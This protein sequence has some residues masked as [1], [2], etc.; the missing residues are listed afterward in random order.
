[1]PGLSINSAASLAD[2]LTLVKSRTSGSICIDGKRAKFKIRGRFHTLF[3][4]VYD[5]TLK[6]KN[7]KVKAKNF[8]S[9]EDAMRR[10]LYK[11][12]KKNKRL[13]K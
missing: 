10:A 11:L 2:I 13:A 8:A 4:Y 5:A 1:M 7:V 12:Q 9:R 6:M 3:R